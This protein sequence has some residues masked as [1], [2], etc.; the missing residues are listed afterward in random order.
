MREKDNF[1][2][3]NTLIFKKYKPIKKIGYGAS[4]NIYSTIRLSDKSVFAM[5]KE[6]KSKS[7][8]RNFLE[9]EAY[10]LYRLQGGLGIPKLITFGYVKNYNILI[11]TLLDK[12]LFKIFIENKRKCHLYEVCL[13][14][15]QLLERLKWIHSKDLIYRDIKPENC[16]IGLS[17]PN[18]IY[19]V[20][21]GLCKQYRS[22]KT[23]KHILPKSTG[24]FNGTLFYASPNAIKGKEISR[25]DDL[26]SLGYMLIFLL[27]RELP[28][29]YYTIDLRESKLFELTYLKD[30][31]GVGKLFKNIPNEFKEYIIY[32]R[33]LKFEQEPDY[34]YLSS[35]FIKIITDMNL[36][37]E[38]ITFSWIDVNERKQL[39][40]IPRSHP[41]RK[42]SSH[43][44][45]YTN[46]ENKIKH[47]LIAKKINENQKQINKTFQNNE[48]IYGGGL[49]KN[50]LHIIKK[51][52]NFQTISLNAFEKGF[53]QNKTIK[54][55]EIKN[56]SNNQK[57]NYIKN[58]NIKTL[59]KI[60]N[61]N[62]TFNN[63]K[64]RNIIIKKIEKRY[65][66]NLSTDIFYKTFFPKNNCN[67]K[68][69]QINYKKRD[70]SL[71]R[72][73]I[74]ITK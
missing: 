67:E 57:S 11:E 65:N 48:M 62:I 29:K 46:I 24:K 43:K 44:R 5:K 9:L 31:N 14:G 13:I 51:N 18:V 16:L 25:R 72:K 61:R 53:P 15:Y 22:S 37:Y 55:E 39:I 28:W 68:K 23:G 47:N 60:N 21:F 54:K 8:K 64:K 17:Y 38:R 42:E 69:N 70:F 41:K 27:K 58:I 49:E 2:E 52:K 34:S 4:G 12:S 56:I 32:S 74:D 33:N 36:D 1:L 26:I 19:I 10:N 6:P 59:K 30:T 50:D 3:D 40:G 66:L 20:D 45:L 35:L 73:E 7:K 71:I 63:I